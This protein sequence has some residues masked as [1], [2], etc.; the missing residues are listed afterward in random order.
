M[1][2]GRIV[3]T[4]DH[5]EDEGELWLECFPT[6]DELSIF[7]E[8]HLDDRTYCETRAD[9]PHFTQSPRLVRLGVAKEKGWA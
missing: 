7:N 5:L 9:A 3:Q 6:V 2:T 1:R 4:P 8:V